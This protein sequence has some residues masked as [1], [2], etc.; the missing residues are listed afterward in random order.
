MRNE[1]GG[2][3]CFHNSA[4]DL[5][6]L[7]CQ[8]AWWFMWLAR[9]KG[10]GRERTFPTDSAWDVA[11]NN[12]LPGPKSLTV[13]RFCLMDD[14][15]RK[16]TVSLLF[17][18]SQRLHHKNVWLGGTLALFLFVYLGQWGSKALWAGSPLTT[19]DLGTSDQAGTP[20]SGHSEH[21]NCTSVAFPT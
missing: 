11:P 20:A 16:A 13:I 18:L 9:E 21:S 17:L 6:I 4:Q 10:E 15:Q 5:L 7:K 2:I 14:Q 1:T 19:R 3:M 8:R 12:P